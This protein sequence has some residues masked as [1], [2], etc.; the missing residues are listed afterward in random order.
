MT[1]EKG[2]APYPL[3]A[4]PFLSRGIQQAV[5]TAFWKLVCL[6]KRTGAKALV[7]SP[8]RRPYGD[9]STGEKGVKGRCSGKLRRSYDE[10][11]SA[12]GQ[13]KLK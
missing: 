12:V 11:I 13:Q 4:C 9:N 3:D 5:G 10:I 8:S 2:E 1:E 7:G 6:G